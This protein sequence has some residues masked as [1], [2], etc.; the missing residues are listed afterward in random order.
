MYYLPRS[1]R[2]CSHM[3]FSAKKYSFFCLVLILSSTLGCSFLQKS[4]KAKEAL[5]LKKKNYAALYN[6]IVSN[7]LQEGI[8][9]QR[10]E[11]LFGKPDEVFQ[12]G[13]MTSNFQVWTYEKV[14][15]KEE[16]GWQL[17]HLYFNNHKLI[18]W[19]Y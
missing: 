3:T 13:T 18:S 7:S 6:D 12:S 9:P 14:M 15:A 19:N 10:I 17:I 8:T 11:E 5:E 1:G 16:T 4:T 2:Q